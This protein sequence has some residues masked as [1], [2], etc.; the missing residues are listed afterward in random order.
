MSLGEE[1]EHHILLRLG[2]DLP[3]PMHV[4][5]AHHARVIVRSR[6]WPGR[7]CGLWMAAGTKTALSWR[8][9]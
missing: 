8:T 2:D 6:S 1:P 4:R 3:N 7:V 9:S 5:A